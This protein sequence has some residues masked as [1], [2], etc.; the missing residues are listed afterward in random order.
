MVDEPEFPA[1]RVFL[2]LSDIHFR[3]GHAGDVHDPDNDLRNELERDLRTISTTRVNRVDGIIVSGDIAFG[4]QNDEFDLARGWLKHIGELI[5]CPADAIMVTPGNHDVD[6]AKV[7]TDGEIDLMHNEVRA[8]VTLAGRDEAIAAILRDGI[9]GPKLLTTID[10]YNEFAKNYNCTVSAMQ[11]FWER[12]FTLSNNGILRIRG[13]TSTLISGPRDDEQTYKMLYGAGQRSSLLRMDSVF[14]VVVGHHPPSW[15]LEGDDA[16]KAFSDRASIQLFGHKHEQW[17]Q[18]VGKSV[19]LIAG[20]VH[21]S[22]QESHWEPR[23]SLLAVR[24]DEQGRLLVR[25][26]PRKWTRE[27]TMFI[28]DCDSQR[29]DFRD[30]VVEPG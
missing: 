21:P 19:R 12:D 26:Y 2:H 15:T 22:R 3:K 5:A 30:H 29:R 6:R 18:R 16:D 10:T 7:P 8:P 13:M 9:R 28:G 4:G 11:P 23:Y 1:D 20:A 25:I 24:L 17:F 14:R 27:E